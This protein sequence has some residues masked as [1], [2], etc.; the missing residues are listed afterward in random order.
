MIRIAIVEDME[1]ERIRMKD[2]VESFFA[3]KNRKVELFIYSDGKYFLEQY[4]SS[5][6]LILLD[7]EMEQL[8]GLQT[9]HRIREFDEK[10]QILFVTRMIQYALEGYSVDAADF[11]VKPIRYPVFCS[12]ME[13]VLRRIKANVPRYLLVRQGKEEV[14]CPVQQIT[15]IE[16]LN[17]KT[18]IHQG[19]ETELQVA[20]P[21]YI[22]E[23]KLAQEPFFRC[24]SGFLVNMSYVQTVSASDVTVDGIRI[25]VSK[26]RR[27]EFMQN[28]AN[29]RGRML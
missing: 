1:Q 3:E 17:K 6:D 20:D 25:P 9:A 23:E 28:L 29:Y 12:R 10:V 21:L 8:D 2:Y 24:H 4:P 27:K 7:I 13:R 26:Y 15:Y 16:S 19:R 22:L 18:I 11:L 14:Y 5:L